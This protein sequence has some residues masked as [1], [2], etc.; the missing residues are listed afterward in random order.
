MC[1]CMSV[2]DKHTCEGYVLVCAYS[3]TC[4]CVWLCVCELWVRSV[5]HMYMCIC[6]CTSM[7]CACICGYMLG[8]CIYKCMYMCRMSA[9]MGYMLGVLKMCVLHIPIGVYVYLNVS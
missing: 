2:C 7:W 3:H 8:V 4:V 9:Y 1:I 5:V 6:L